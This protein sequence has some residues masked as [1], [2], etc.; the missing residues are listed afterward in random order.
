MMN[1]GVRPTVSS[2][3]QRVIE[4]HVLD[5]SRDIYDERMSVT[6]LRRL[7]DERKFGSVQELVEQ[8]DK[9][10]DHARRLISSLSYTPTQPKE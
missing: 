6:F 5:F 3:V 8:L 4:V 10:R 7:R 2:G 1:I 9:D